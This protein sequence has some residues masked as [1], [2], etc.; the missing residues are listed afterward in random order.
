MLIKKVTLSTA[1]RLLSYLT[2]FTNLIKKNDE[3]R[4]SWNDFEKKKNKKPGKYD[5]RDTAI[6]VSMN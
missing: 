6:I 2:N 4:I 3:L 1:P 5:Q